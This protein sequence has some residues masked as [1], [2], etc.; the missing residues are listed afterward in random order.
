MKNKLSILFFIVSA[1]FVMSCSSKY[2]YGYIYDR[3]EE[4]PLYGVKITLMRSDLETYSDANG[5][6]KIPKVKNRASSLIF[7]KEPHYSDTIKSFW[8]Q[9]GEKVI[10]RFRGEKIFLLKNK[11]RDSIL[12]LSAN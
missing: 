7:H 3:I 6:F 10:L 11:D 8:I 5:Y 1:M 9:S 12:K 4:K 2:Y